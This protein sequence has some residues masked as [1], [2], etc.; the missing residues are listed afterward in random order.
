MA[1]VGLLNNII[2]FKLLLLI[3]TMSIPIYSITMNKIEKG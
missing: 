2:Y 3:V 1:I